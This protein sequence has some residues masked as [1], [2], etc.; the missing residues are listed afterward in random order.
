MT[1]KW[2]QAEDEF[3]RLAIQDKQ[4]ASQ[5]AADLG[6]AYPRDEPRTRMAIVG[7]AHRL[8]LSFDKGVYQNGQGF[9]Q[10]AVTRRM[11]AREDAE[12]RR[13]EYQRKL[14]AAV[15][16]AP[17]AAVPDPVQPPPVE[18]V[19]ARDISAYQCRWPRWGDIK[20]AYADMFYCGAVVTR[21]GSYCD[22][23][24]KLAFR[25]QGDTR[26]FVHPSRLLKEAGR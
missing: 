3:I 2:S 13:I 21:F 10:L 18:G 17:V 23:C 24:R 14:A 19:H 20:P 4:T 9:T 1:R 7:R 5:T 6:L 11:K 22:E 26:K 12:R 8:G 16:A 15:L 25:P